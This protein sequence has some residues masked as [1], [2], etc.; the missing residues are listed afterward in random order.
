MPPCPE[1]TAR[2]Q[3]HHVSALR[4]R[5]TGTVAQATICMHGV[6]K[7]PSDTPSPPPI[8]MQATHS[9]SPPQLIAHVTCDV[10][11]RAPPHMPLQASPVP[12]PG[13]VFT[14]TVA[15]TGPPWIGRKGHLSVG[16]CQ[17]G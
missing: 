2:L 5:G 14:S 4:A 15:C 7:T 3:H 12:D 11:A 10:Q 1:G 8:G 9:I 6:Q 17:G 16:S 13:L